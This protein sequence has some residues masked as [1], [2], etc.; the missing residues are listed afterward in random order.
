MYKIL[1]FNL[2]K[3]KNMYGRATAKD[4]DIEMS[5]L[6]CQGLKDH[7]FKTAGQRPAVMKIRLFKSFARML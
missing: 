1:F 4:N 5:E 3:N 7:I 2:L 6:H